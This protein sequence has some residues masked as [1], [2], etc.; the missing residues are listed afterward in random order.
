[1]PPGVYSLSIRTSEQCSDGQSENT[2]KEHIL[3]I[4]YSYPY[5][6]VLWVR[7]VAISVRSSSTKMVTGQKGE[8]S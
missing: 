5:I 8:Y 1:M 4:T 3:Y 6:G 7:R 2:C